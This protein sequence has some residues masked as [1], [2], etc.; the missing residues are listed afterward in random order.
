M[1]ARIQ[2]ASIAISGSNVSTIACPTTRPSVYFIA[3][4]GICMSHSRASSI[5]E[6]RAICLG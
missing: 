3:D 5:F 4:N 2:L 1:S 6:R